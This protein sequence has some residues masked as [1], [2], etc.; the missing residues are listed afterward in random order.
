MRVFS[1]SLLLIGV[2]LM[3]TGCSQSDSSVSGTIDAAV[4]G[5]VEAMDTVAPPTDTPSPT[6][7]PS[8]SSTP[9]PLDTDTPTPSPLMLTVSSAT[10]CRMGPATAYKLVTAI[11]PGEVVEVAAKSGDDDFWYV[12]N[13]ANPDEFCWL[14]GEYVTLEG[15][16]SLLPVFTPEPSPTPRIGFTTYLYGFYE[17]GDEFVVLTVVNSSATTFMSASLR[18]DDI[19]DS[20]ALHSRIDRH[21]FAQVPQDCPPDH[22]NFFPPGAAAFIWM[23]LGSYTAGNDAMATIKLCTKDY[24]GGD[25][26]TEVAYFR[27]PN[28]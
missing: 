18:A 25:C 6:L 4:A 8:P 7:T 26:V 20:V 28:K 11:Q 3:A 1:G 14:W 13:P 12:A 10:N 17:C 5:T 23:P 22:G 27:L 21:P 9:V 15:D 24:A 16:A 19:T 2:L